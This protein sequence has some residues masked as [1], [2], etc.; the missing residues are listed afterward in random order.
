MNV[1]GQSNYERDSKTMDPQQMITEIVIDYFNELGQLI[2]RAK[3]EGR[4]VTLEECDHY[5][6]RGMLKIGLF[7]ESLSN[8]F[9]HGL[10][11]DVSKELFNQTSMNYYDYMLQ[12]FH[13]LINSYEERPIFDD[14]KSSNRCIKHTKSIKKLK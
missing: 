11:S 7:V 4:Y 14:I 12:V 8:T 13:E 10:S 3:A 1:R 2:I 6:A 5:Y 9:N